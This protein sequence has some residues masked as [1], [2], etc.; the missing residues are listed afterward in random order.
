MIRFLEFLFLSVVLITSSCNR[1]EV[2][3]TELPPRILLDEGTTY[4]VKQGYE[5]RIA[6]RYENVASASFEW[7]ME[8]EVVCRERA[9]VFYGEGVGAFYVELTVTTH[10]GSDTVEFRI[11]VTE[12]ETPTISILGDEQRIVALG[13]SLMLD[14]QMRS[15]SL[16]TTV[17]WL[18]ADEVVGSGLQYTFRAEAV[19]V[20]EVVVRAT[21][22]DGVAEDSVSCEVRAAEDM[23][24]IY[25]F[26]STEYHGVCGR[27]I[28]ITPT[29][30]SVNGDVS[31]RWTVDGAEVEDY[32]AAGYTLLCDTAG[33]HTVEVCAEAVVGDAKVNISHSFTVSVYDEA[34][35]C[36]AATSESLATCTRVYEYMPAPGQFINELRT[37]GFDATHTTMAAACDYAEERMAA[38]SWVSL[39]GFGGYIVVGFDHSIDNSADYDLAIIGNSFD[40]SSEPGVV[41]VMQDENG[42]GMPDD[43]WYELAGSETGKAETVQH[44]AVTYYRPSGAQMPVRWSDNLGNSG[45]IDYLSQFHTQDYYYPLWVEEASYTLTGTR[46]EARNYDSSGNGSIWIQ[47]HYDWGYVDN[48]SPTDFDTATRSNLLDISHARDFEGEAVTLS[49]IDFVKVQCAVNAKSGWL[50]ELSTEVCGFMDYNLTE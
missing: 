6:P 43:T 5:I 40:G 2:I 41:W 37:G 11:D 42:N 29:R 14:A 35:F 45:E 34:S 3:S 4:S 23:P 32:N 27:K 24:F 26:A 8:G 9:F 25:E 7:T 16:D 49:H 18:L 39:G 31:Y 21:N 30:L 10:V 22:A 47:P 50:G 36:R 19:G 44:Y 46:L 12:R 15:T 20:Y 38:G 17:E 33:S 1:D 13:E 48:C 28:L